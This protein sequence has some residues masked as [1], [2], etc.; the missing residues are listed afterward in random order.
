MYAPAV[1]SVELTSVKTGESL[2]TNSPSHNYNHMSKAQSSRTY[3]YI[4]EAMI[5]FWIKL[6]LHVYIIY[7]QFVPILVFLLFFF[8]CYT[9]HL[10]KHTVLNL[11]LP[12]LH[13]QFE[14]T[15]PLLE[16]GRSSL[17][18]LNFIES[19]LGCSS[20]VFRDRVHCF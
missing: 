16:T 3:V 20:I 13:S 18:P 17:Q 1:N 6:H 10:F 5:L 15:I 8:L 11:H 7:H 2:V 4:V 12:S 14:L 19:P 9:V